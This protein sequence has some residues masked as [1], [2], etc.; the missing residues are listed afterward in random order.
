MFLYENLWRGL[1]PKDSGRPSGKTKEAYPKGDEV[2]PPSLYNSEDGRPIFDKLSNIPDSA[3]TITAN[4]REGFVAGA[5]PASSVVEWL[6]FARWLGMTATSGLRA[7]ILRDK[8]DQ[9]CS[10]ASATST[11]WVAGTVHPVLAAQPRG[12]E[13]VESAYWTSNSIIDISVT[14]TDHECGVQAPSPL[15]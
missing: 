13:G 9:I 15:T 11:K 10:D 1:T 14:E 2:A 3:R 8:T 5:L 12:P 7:A 6:I 4:Q